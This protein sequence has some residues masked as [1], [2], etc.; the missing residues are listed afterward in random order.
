MI[1]HKKCLKD[2]PK[3]SL[4]QAS[5]NNMELT[6]PNNHKLQASYRPSHTAAFFVIHWNTEFLNS[7][8]CSYGAESDYPNIKLRW[9]R[10]GVC[11]EGAIEPR[12]LLVTPAMLH[13]GPTAG[14]DHAEAEAGSQSSSTTPDYFNSPSFAISS[15]SPCL[16]LICSDRQVL[17]PSLCGHSCS[18]HP[19]ASPGRQSTDPPVPPESKAPEEE[20][21]C[22]IE[23]C[24]PS[25]TTLKSFSTT[26]K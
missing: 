25:K 7:A 4:T 23:R 5:P 17:A 13:P 2:Q 18:A 8:G 15:S 11:G 22:N 3:Q 9:A 1:N 14:G 16:Y 24:R 6:P 20:S 21:I 19:S 12:H 10:P 26:G